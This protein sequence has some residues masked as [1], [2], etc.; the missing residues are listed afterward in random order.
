MGYKL[1]DAV[2]KPIVDI[3]NYWL[4]TGRSYELDFSSAAAIANGASWNT[5]I[6]TGSRPVVIDTM[7]FQM[8]EEAAQLWLYRTPTGTAGGV[9]AT[10]FNLNDVTNQLG[11]NASL[12]QIQVGVTATTNG[13]QIASARTVIG[14]NI[15]GAA[16]SVQTIHE[17]T[18]RVLAPNSVYLF[19]VVNTSSAANAFNMQLSWTE[20]DLPYLTNP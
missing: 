5:R 13:N 6:I 12:C 17:E 4:Y 15:S 7:E 10:P 8:S 18:R 11:V 20:Q 19:R 9:P 14:N 3:T 1:D 2:P 16:F